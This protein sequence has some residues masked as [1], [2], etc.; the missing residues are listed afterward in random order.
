MGFRESLIENVKDKEDNNDV[1]DTN[2][3][4]EA[5][6][7]RHHFL[8]RLHHRGVRVE[9]W[10]WWNEDCRRIEFYMWENKIVVEAYIDCKAF[11]DVITQYFG[12]KSWEFVFHPMLGNCHYIAHVNFQPFADL[13]LVEFKFSVAGD[14]PPEFD[15][16]TNNHAKYEL[17][18]R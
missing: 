17:Q 16:V 5:I 2:E 15:V 10:N 11:K 14:I 6:A 9:E 7:I 13:P 1:W 18:K 8:N 3:C 12:V 4:Q